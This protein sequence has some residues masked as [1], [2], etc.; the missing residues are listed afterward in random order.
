LGA[1]CASVGVSKERALFAAEKSSSVCVRSGNPVSL[2][3]DLALKLQVIETVM[4][5][6]RLTAMIL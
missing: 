5:G 6:K 1:S 4:Y 3:D 2:N